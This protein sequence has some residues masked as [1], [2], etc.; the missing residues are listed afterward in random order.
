M[1][2]FCLQVFGQLIEFCVLLVAVEAYP[3]GILSWNLR[4]S[5]KPCICFWQLSRGIVVPSSLTDCEPLSLQSQPLDL[6]LCEIHCVLVSLVANRCPLFQSGSNHHQYD[7][8]IFC[9]QLSHVGPWLFPCPAAEVS[10]CPS[11]N[12]ANK[13][14][15]SIN[16][17]PKKMGHL[18][19]APHGLR[20]RDGGAF[21]KQGAGTWW[22]HGT[23]GSRG[24]SLGLVGNHHSWRG[25]N[26]VGLI[27]MGSTL[28]QCRLELRG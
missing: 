15:K 18:P 19:K 21:D 22:R 9:G 3:F 26:T 11:E 27:N 25:T 7:G 28:H 6:Q 2:T 24:M 12:E 17:P 13:I 4:A 10:F 14:N 23:W 8:L 16:P 20:R 5:W 1:I